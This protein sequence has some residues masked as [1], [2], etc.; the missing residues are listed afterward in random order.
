MRKY[1]LEI[2]GLA[3]APGGRCPIALSW[4]LI[5]VPPQ[6]VLKAHGLADKKI[7]CHAFSDRYVYEVRRCNAG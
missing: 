1:L 2:S 7:F 4:L 6:G 3:F 5:V